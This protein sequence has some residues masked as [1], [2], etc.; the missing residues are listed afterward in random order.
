MS[1]PKTWFV[2]GASRG[3]GRRWTETAL[4]RGDKVAATAR[5]P[6]SL[7]ALRSQYGEAV[8]PLAL[9]VTNHEEVVRSVNDAHQH[10]GRL[11]V[12]LSV[13]GYGY[14][15]A[16]EEVSMQ[17]ARANFD[18]NVFGT[19]SVIQAALPLL[20]AQGSGHILPVSSAGGIVAFPTGGIY[21]ATKF[22]VEGLAE[23]LAGEVAGFG[24]KVTIIEPGP[25]ATDF[26]NESSVRQA[27]PMPAY[28]T[29]RQHLASMLTTDAFG[30]P[31]ATGD[32]ILKVV[33]S[34]EPP[35]RLILGTM[36]PLV[37]QVYAE[38]LKVWESWESVSNAA[39]GS[40]N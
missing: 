27:P 23:A 11:D 16:V 40:R 14:M 7:E 6:Q 8:L 35:L 29:V 22:A 25:F 19:L 15:G 33:D 10:F 36:L 1:S 17:D 12:V 9:D 38:R 30:D 28:D 26:M 24:I 13:A 39:Q 34:P 3:F 21:E 5:D 18:T 37:K 20:R 31:C 32:A 4:A 2:T